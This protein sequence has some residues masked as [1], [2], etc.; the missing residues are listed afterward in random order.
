MWLWGQTTN[1][2]FLLHDENFLTFY[3]SSSWPNL[4]RFYSFKILF[5][6]FLNSTVYFLLSTDSLHILFEVNTRL[7]LYYSPKIKNH[8]SG[9]TSIYSL[10]GMHFPHVICVFDLKNVKFS[11]HSRRIKKILYSSSFED[12]RVFATSQVTKLWTGKLLIFSLPLHEEESNG[13]G[14]EEARQELFF[15]SLLLISTDEFFFT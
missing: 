8:S 3:F 6:C 12:W 14:R 4:T 5:W 1:F 7:I 9:F 15:V 10:L 13:E 2:L 11:P